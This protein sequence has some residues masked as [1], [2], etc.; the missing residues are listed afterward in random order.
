MIS[1]DLVRDQEIMK[2]EKLSAVP[3]ITCYKQHQMA[4]EL[5]YA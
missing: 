3:K 2:T 5:I 1:E 4:M